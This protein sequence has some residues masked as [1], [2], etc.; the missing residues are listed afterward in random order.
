MA[1]PKLAMLEIHPG[2]N[3]GHRVVHTFQRKPMMRAGSMAGGMSTD[4]PPDEEHNFGP[5]E[6]QQHALMT[7]IAK[8]LGFSKVA[9]AEGEEDAEG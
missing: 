8:A 1:A 2:A 3:G 6:K 4:R 5:E 7:H 9:A